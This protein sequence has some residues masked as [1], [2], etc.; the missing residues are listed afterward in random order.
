[1][2]L[3]FSQGVATAT[4][5]AAAGGGPFE[6][7]ILWAGVFPPDVDLGPDA[8]QLRNTPLTCVLGDADPFFG[9]GLLEETDT[10]LQA[11]GLTASTSRFSGGHA[12]CSETLLRVLGEGG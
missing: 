5:W 11:A 6:Q 12:I 3:G 1:V 7:L 10:R 8:D 4:R 2:L 9:V